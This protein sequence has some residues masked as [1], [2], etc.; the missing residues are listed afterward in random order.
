MAEESEV[1]GGGQTGESISDRV[2]VK[3]TIGRAYKM[4]YGNANTFLG[5]AAV[6]SFPLFAAGL[7]T[8]HHPEA[9]KPDLLGLLSLIL[10]LGALVLGIYYGGAIPLLTA[11]KLD[12]RPMGWTDAFGW[13]HDKRLFWGVFLVLLLTLLAFLGGL[14]LLI[15]PGLLFLVWFSLGASAR[16]L[17]DFPGRKALSESR[18]LMQ[19]VLTRG[20]AG[21]LAVLIA[22]PLVI[23]GAANGICWAIWGFGSRAVPQ[24]LITSIVNYALGVFWGPVAYV[25]LAIV[26]VELSGGLSKLRSDLFL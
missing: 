7:L 1:Q 19:P 15:V 4:C 14:I 12:N 8:M 3:D 22:V 25:S 9:G 13:I 21:L 2:R 24:V 5:M 20:G 18:R 17:G 16:V 10:L 23:G 26:Y 11:F 6:V